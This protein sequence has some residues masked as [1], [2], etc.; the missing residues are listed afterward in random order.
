MNKDSTL[1]F[2]EKLMT[3]NSLLTWGQS[4]IPQL[5]FVSQL[6]PKDEIDCFSFSVNAS[7]EYAG[8][9]YKNN[10]ASLT[11]WLGYYEYYG[12]CIA[13]WSPNRNDKDFIIH[14]LDN[15][16]KECLC[17]YIDYQTNGKTEGHWI[18][19]PLHVDDKDILAEL[20]DILKIFKNNS[21]K[22]ILENK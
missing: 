4:N 18:H 8:Q 11:I 10:K 1:S 9:Y 22:S 7:Y 15:H 14:D 12:F 17:D 16:G 5:G 13:F 3:L 6:S 19:V 2:T 21:L 20:D